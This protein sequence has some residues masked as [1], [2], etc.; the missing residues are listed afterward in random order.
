MNRLAELLSVFA[1][2]EREQESYFPQ[3]EGDA[4]VDVG[5]YETTTR[6]A[7]FA[8]LCALADASKHG[9]THDGELGQ[10]C[11]EIAAITTL[12]IESSALWEWL[13]WH[14]TMVRTPDLWTG[15]SP[16]PMIYEVWSVLRR[17]CKEACREMSCSTQPLPFQDVLSSV[18]T[19]PT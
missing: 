2:T 19:Y 4:W 13:V 9:E 5:V 8:A 7:R 18:I 15:I 6:F 14:P 16:D 11:S 3:F 1:L 10:L 12:L 17:L